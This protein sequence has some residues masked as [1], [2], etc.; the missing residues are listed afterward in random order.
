[1][2]QQQAHAIQWNLLQPELS[3][4]EWVLT[5]DRKSLF[6]AS[7]RNSVVES[8]SKE[9][10]LFQKDLYSHTIVGCPRNRTPT[11]GCIGAND[12]SEKPRAIN[13]QPDFV[14]MCNRVYSAFRIVGDCQKCVVFLAVDVCS[15]H[16]SC[17]YC[18]IS[19]PFTA[20]SHFCCS[21]NDLNRM[22]PYNNKIIRSTDLTI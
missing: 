21:N 16:S 13:L 19:L 18:R 8:D 5:V 1:M 22:P 9:S 15:P 20:T 17:S 11:A 12:G 7:N 4:I 14:Y 6:D 10:K 2:Q 3:A